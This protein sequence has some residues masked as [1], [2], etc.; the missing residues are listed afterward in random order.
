MLPFFCSQATQLASELLKALSRG[1]KVLVE[2]AWRGEA[3][4]AAAGRAPMPK[5]SLAAERD[6]VAVSWSDT[7]FGPTSRVLIRS[8]AASLES[9]PLSLDTPSGALTL[10]PIDAAARAAWVLGLNAAFHAHAI[11]QAARPGDWAV[12]KAELENAVI[13]LPWHPAVYLAPRGARA[14]DAPPA[15]HALPAMTGGAR[16]VLDAL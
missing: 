2:R 5:L 11:A 13:G 1:R 8:V 10:H 3:G 15:G 7:R 4:A 6:G 14:A 9:L 16:D 12:T